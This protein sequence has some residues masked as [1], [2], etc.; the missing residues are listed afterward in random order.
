V[1]FTITLERSTASEEATSGFLCFSIVGGAALPPL[2]GLVSQH[3]SYVTAFIVPA[4][5]YAVLCAFALASRKARVR[6]QDEPAIAT[7]H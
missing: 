5:C 2:T 7:I 1:I 6:L 3:T 4:A